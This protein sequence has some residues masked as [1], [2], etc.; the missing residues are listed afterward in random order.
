MDRVE[1]LEDVATVDQHAVLG[2]DAFVCPL[3]GI[4]GGAHG[5]APREPRLVL[6]RQRGDAARPEQQAG[7]ILERSRGDR[8]AVDHGGTV[9]AV[10]LGRVAVLTGGDEQ[11]ARRVAAGDLSHHARDPGLHRREL[12]G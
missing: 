3:G 9:V 6:S 2:A 5:V 4:G 10:H 1:L 8:Q 7:Q 12:V 11:L